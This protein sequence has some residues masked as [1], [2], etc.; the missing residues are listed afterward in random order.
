MEVCES[1]AQRERDTLWPT[2]CRKSVRARVRLSTCPERERER[3]SLPTECRE[4]CESLHC[5]K[6]VAKTGNRR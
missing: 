1:L 5:A 2:E 4:V 3:D 6:H